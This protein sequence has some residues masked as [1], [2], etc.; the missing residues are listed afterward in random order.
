MQRSAG[1][2]QRKKRLLAQRDLPVLERSRQI[3]SKQ[4][5][6]QSCLNDGWIQRIH[7]IGPY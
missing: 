2:P 7:E 1:D 6:R 3:P 4:S 5:Q